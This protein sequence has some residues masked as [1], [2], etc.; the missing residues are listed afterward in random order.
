MSTKI[1]TVIEAGLANGVY[2][3]REQALLGTAFDAGW[4]DKFGVPGDWAISTAYA[5]GR[6]VTGTDTAVYRCILAHT[7]TADDRPITGANWETYWIESPVVEVLNLMENVTGF[8]YD[9]GLA[10]GDRIMA[11][12]ATDCAGE[13]MYMGKPLT[14][15][16][17]K[18]RL[19]ATPGANLYV[20]ANLF[21]NDGTTEI[22]SGLGSYILANF[23]ITYSAKLDAC[24]PKLQ[25]NDDIFVSHIAGRWW[26]TTVG[27]AKENCVCDT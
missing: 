13:T 4:G 23:Y 17:R 3:C 6:L 20:Y 11:W 21:A 19:R 25:D 8:G 18:A 5:L 9:R 10:A 2:N 14:P 16:V 27:Q 1:Y 24:S 7:S 26:C 15:S 22:T 12:E